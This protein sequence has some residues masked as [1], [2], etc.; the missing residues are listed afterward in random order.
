MAATYRVT[1][2]AV[3]VTIGPAYT[4]APTRMR[5]SSGAAPACSR[6]AGGAVRSSRRQPALRRD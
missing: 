3:A 4:V 5:A 6:A 1:A 2:T